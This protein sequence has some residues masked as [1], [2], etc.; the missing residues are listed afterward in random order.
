MPYIY[1]VEQ[2]KSYYQCVNCSRR[3]LQV[4]GASKICRRDRCG[5]TMRA[6]N[7]EI[8]MCAKLVIKPKDDEQPVHLTAFENALKTALKCDV[9]CLSE[10]EIAERLLLLDELTV[11]YNPRSMIITEFAL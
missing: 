10:E 6:A 4:T 2:V 9:A 5:Y 11:S 3:L 8:Q 1:C 7:C